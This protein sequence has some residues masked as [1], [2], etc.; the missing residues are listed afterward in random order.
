MMSEIDPLYFTP[1]EFFKGLRLLYNNM[2]FKMFKEK[3]FPEEH[4]TYEY[5]QSYFA[6]WG[7][8][9]F[10]LWCNLDSNKREVLEFLIYECAKKEA[11]LWGAVS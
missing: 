4:H 9:P 10:G 11:Q 7:R 2:D 3:L 1:G 6:H 5:V 8:N